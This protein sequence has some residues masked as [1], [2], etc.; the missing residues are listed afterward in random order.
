MHQIL[1][2]SLRS[3]LTIFFL[4]SKFIMPFEE[5]LTSLRRHFS[6]NVFFTTFLLPASMSLLCVFCFIE[7][8]KTETLLTPPYYIFKTKASPKLALQST[9][10]C[11]AFTQSR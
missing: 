2:L 4:F 6:H 9:V 7:A 3:S 10:Y 5:F 11:S 8:K 1:S